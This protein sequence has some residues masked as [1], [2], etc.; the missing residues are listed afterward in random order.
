MN[1]LADLQAATMAARSSTG[2]PIG[3]RVRRGKFQVVSV[4]HMSNGDSIVDPLSDWV[5]FGD[6][7]ETLRQIAADKA[8]R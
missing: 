2:M 7:V 8:F 6:A 5:T 1:L 3:T 4:T